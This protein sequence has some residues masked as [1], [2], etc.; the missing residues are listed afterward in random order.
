VVE[1][2]VRDP[3][4]EALSFTGSVQI[5]RAI[6]HEAGYK[7]LCLELGGNSPLIVLEDAD[8]ELAA[9]LALEGSFRN[10]GQRCTAV[11]RIL[12]QRRAG[13]AFLDALM[14]QAPAWTAGDPADPDSAIGTVIDEPAAIE[15]ERRI[16]QAEEL[17]ARVLHG[18]DRRGALL[19]PA[20]LTDVPRHA[21]LV[22]LESFGPIAPVVWIDDLDD[23]IAYYHSGT[24]G[25]SSA[26]VTNNLELALKACRRLR[27]G[28][29]NVNEV[30]GYR[31]EHTPFGGVGDSG[32]G[33]KE[34]V[35]EAVRF[36]SWEKT[37]SLPW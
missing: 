36:F 8:M 1:P 14:C 21:D 6:A 22:V 9:R 5:G 27:T 24:F 20:I 34:G 7:K 17:G 33:I 25:L 32:L 4:I 31:L 3:R 15:L 35:T 11:K 10:S 28:T 37:Y 16:R 19:Q 29:T 30:P 13:Q 12:V 23:A 18:G 26:V 2:L